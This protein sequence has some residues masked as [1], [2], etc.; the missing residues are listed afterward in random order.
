[1]TLSLVDPGWNE[2]ELPDHPHGCLVQLGMTAAASH[3]DLFGHGA[4]HLDQKRHQRSSADPGRAKL[5]RIFPSQYFGEVP[6]R[7]QPR[8]RVKD[9]ESVALGNLRLRLTRR[10][11]DRPEVSVARA[12]RQSGT[13]KNKCQRVSHSQPFRSW[14]MTFTGW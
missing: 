3:L 11:I 13:G 6:G 9:P 12:P 10:E 14:Q 1:M 2:L 7:R 5:T 8:R 4:I